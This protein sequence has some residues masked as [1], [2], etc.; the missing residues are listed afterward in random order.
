MT[1]YSLEEVFDSKD[2]YKLFIQPIADGMENAMTL[3]FTEKNIPVLNLGKKVSEFIS[4][5]DNYKYLHM[6]VVDYIQ[7]V[8]N[9]TRKMP[10]AKGNN[11]L[12]ITNL[13][14]LLEPTLEINSSILLKE[15]SK[16]TSLIILWENEIQDSNKLTWKTQ[17]TKYFLDFSDINLKILQHAV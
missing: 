11:V 12:A 4:G 7:R 10:K 8:F 16:S 6:D 1:N 3:K 13:G 15:Y 5:L 2:H 17:K 9:E 14:I